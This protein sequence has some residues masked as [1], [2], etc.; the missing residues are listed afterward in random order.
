[1]ARID[2]IYRYPVKGLSAAPLDAVTLTAGEGLPL[3]RTFALACAGTAFDP[4][5]PVWLAKRHF[6]MLMR[7]ERLALLAVTYDPSRLRI[8]QDGRE[9]LDAD[10]GTAAGR[11][12]I[13]DFFEA[14]MAGPAPC[15]D[16]AAANANPGPLA[17][18]AA[19]RG[20]GRPRL[21][22]S[23]GHMFTDNP[24]P[25]VSLIN[26]ATVREIART[27]GRETLDPLR[28]RA[29]LYIDDLEPWAELD[30]VG[31]ELAA[32]DVRF[33]CAERI[34]RCAATNVDPTTAARDLNIPQALRQVYGHIDC[35]VLLGVTKGGRLERGQ[36]IGRPT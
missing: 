25:Y 14:F 4:A 30:W 8:R 7:D 12:A 35:G 17:G 15:S 9:V 22:R 11:A 16:P 2:R 18:G 32:G 3:D 28:F 21:V 6:L 27:L 31:H 33:A 5:Q 34:D 10:T 1:M 20:A 24:T 29:N 13:E 36:A 23:P 26:L 19:S